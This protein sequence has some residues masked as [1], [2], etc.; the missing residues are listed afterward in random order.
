MEIS[1]K[2]T[3]FSIDPKNKRCNDCGEKHI[4]YV[5]I[6][7]GITI[8]NLCVQI[9][10]QLGPKISELKKI[11]E[12][13]D[14]YTM[15]FFIY[16]GNKNFHKFLKELGVNSSIQ[17]SKLY[18]TKGADYYRKYLLAKVKGIENTAKKPDDPNELI[19]IEN[20]QND[21]FDNIVNDNDDDNKIKEEKHSI[22]NINNFLNI[23]NNLGNKISLKDAENIHGD[24]HVQLNLGN[25]NI[26][27]NEKNILKKNFLRSSMHKMKSLGGYIK[28]NS[29]KGITAM[30]KAGN[31]IA[32]KSKPVAEKIKTKAKYMGEHIPHFHIGKYRSQDDIRLDHNFEDLKATENVDNKEDKKDENEN[33]KQIEF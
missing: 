14:D 12:D 17:R 7:N 22:N 31:I 5:S 32:K 13:F 26:Q 29:I 8:C 20:K 2:Q 27:S 4:S 18:K 9:H 24:S 25:T 21:I 23:N 11:D 3:L 1:F 30:K 28:K 33:N 19:E 10:R 15:N 6:N 16:G